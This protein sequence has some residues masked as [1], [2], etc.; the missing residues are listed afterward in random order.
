MTMGFISGRRNGLRVAVCLL[1]LVG[2]PE[3]GQA[4]TETFRWLDPNPDPSPVIA[5]S[6]Y[7]RTA[8]G[9][10]EGLDVGMPSPDLEGVYSASVEVAA[11]ATEVAMKSRDDVGAAS[12]LSNTLQLAPNGHIDD[13]TGPIAISAGE[14]VSFAGSVEGG[15][16]PDIDYE[17]VFSGPSAILPSDVEDPGPVGFAVAGV[18]TVA[19]T[20]TDGR[21]LADPSPATLIVTVGE[22]QAPPEAGSTGN[23]LFVPA[24]TSVEVE[25]V[26]TGLD[27]P[28]YLTAPVGDS[29]LFVVESGG[30]I[31]IVVD[32]G[33]LAVPF[34]DL[35]SDVSNAQEGG[36]LSLA[37]DPD[38]AQNGTFYVYRTDTDGVSLL[39]RFRVSEDRDVADAMSEEVILSVDQ[40]F[41]DQNGGSIAFDPD[42]G[43][44]YLGLGDGGSLND[45]A[46]RAQDGGEL[47]GK[48]LRLD[49]GQPQAPGSVPNGTYA[50]PADNPFV[51]NPNVHDEV[52]ALGLRNPYRFTFD[53][54]LFDLWLTDE[55]QDAREEINFEFRGDAGGQ[56]YGWDVMEGA[57]CNENDP[58]P[59]PP[60]DDPSLVL[61]FH[62]Y[63]HTGGNCAI[64]GGYVYRGTTAGLWGH[65]FFSDFCSGG[66]W[67][68]QRTSGEG[69]NWTQALGSAAGAP[70]Q[71]VSFGEGGAGDLYI[72]H[73]DGS[74]YRIG[75]ANP[76]CSDGL[77]NDGDGFIDVGSDPGCDTA[78]SNLED[79][80][81]DDGLDNDGDNLVDTVDPQCAVPSWNAEG[82]SPEEVLGASE[83][84]G[85]GGKSCGIGFELVFVLPP[86]MW[87]RRRRWRS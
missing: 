79:P 73:K 36:L 51:G 53:R 72:L 37:F 65:Y 77:D 8:S 4:R 49:V 38:Y 43:F 67:S 44:L 29:R 12:F 66:V 6:I 68:I 3:T 15:V 35:S 20:V 75:A 86:L 82:Q 33:V 22:A 83:S 30:V 54:A 58:S 34:L 46:D 85:G 32:G 50:I 31:R 41:D 48:L 7:W 45:P 81:C 63:P 24:S 18:Y 27:N 52:W 70:D 39:S 74:I 78:S 1:L 5:F 55:G 28:V 76:E 16:G 9:W 84:D 13:P 64:T 62:D 26:A 42:D 71:I 17:W 2:L 10:S 61:P 21:D 14:T 59:S 69:T 25:R 40:P 60:C 47:L 87:L 80:Q 23:E 57:V 56:N 19:L 11:D